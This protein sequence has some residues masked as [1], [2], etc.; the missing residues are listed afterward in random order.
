MKGW[1]GMSGSD[2]VSNTLPGVSVED[3][4]TLKKTASQEASH[5]TSLL[6]TSADSVDL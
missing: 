3:G 5:D 2:S 4:N 6:E 1:V